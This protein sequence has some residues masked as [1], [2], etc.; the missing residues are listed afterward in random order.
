MR[1]QRREEYLYD[2]LDQH[3]ACGVGFVAEV[4]G[5][6]SHSIIQTAL[7]ALGNLT[8]R[9]AVDADGRTGDGAG[10]LTQLPLEF[11]RREA[12]RLGYRSNH[13]AV[14]VFFL[15]RDETVA[16]GCRE[17]ITRTSEKHGLAPL[18]WRPV[19]VN[20]RVL[21]AK[22]LST[23]PRIEQFLV[24]CGRVSPS[25]FE[26]TLYSARRELE[27]HTA[28]IEGF[29]ISSFSSRTIVYKGLLTGS[30]LGQF[31]TDLTVT[32]FKA[33]L[34]V[35]HQRYSTNTFPNWALAQPFR[36]LAHNGE[37]NTVSG[38]RSWMRARELAKIN[39]SPEH[40]AGQGSV[41]WN[42][43]SD[44]ASLDNALELSVRSGR[45]LTESV[46][47]LIP[48]A[49]ETADEMSPDLRAFYDY[50]ASLTET[51]GRPSSR[52]LH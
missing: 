27:Q 23:A 10:L 26:T 41:I 20:E 28:E 49:Y 18:G 33:A 38:N 50:A 13:L 29:Y 21:G 15:P 3:D 11:F 8:H 48:E 39:R 36:L 30:Q 51:V 14:G 16:A 45:E 31:Y 46:M 19:P 9:G 34:A 7:E 6:A 5:C 24:D 1:N 25:Q 40:A 47:M 35:F 42:K 52:G 22:A 4:S 44:S 43:G 32:D 17:I 2:P 37:I 12:E